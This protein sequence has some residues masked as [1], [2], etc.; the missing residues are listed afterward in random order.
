[1][2]TLNRIGVA[3]ST[4]RNTDSLL[5][6][7]LTKSREITCCDA[8]S[9]Y[10]VEEEPAGGRRLVFKLTQS[11]SHSPSFQEYSLEIDEKSAAG[12]A[13]AT[14]SILNIPD[15]YKIESLPFRFNPGFDQKYKYR[16]KSMLVV[17]M[18]NHQNE[19]IGV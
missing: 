7:I 10:L 4:E 19:V 2:A 16:T 12:Y 17:P 8:G 18:E 11:D 1:L 13:A 6:L 5:E 15:A 9:L 14:R 3:L